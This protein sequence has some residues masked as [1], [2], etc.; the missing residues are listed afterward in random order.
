MDTILLRRFRFTATHS[1]SLAHLSE[2]ENRARFGA[3]ADPHSHD[4][5]V[6]VGVGGEREVGTG[7]VTD[8]GELARALETLKS[9]LN[10]SHL[11]D[12]IDVF[13]A[14]TVLPSCEQ[15]AAWVYSRVSTTVTD[16]IRWV[17]VFESDD[18]GAEFRPGS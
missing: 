14:R 7:F 4:Y 16:P 8:L 6:E 1:Y 13:H 17:R 11:N 12:S 15:L 2:E 9:Q 10:E 3:L 5:L 18:L